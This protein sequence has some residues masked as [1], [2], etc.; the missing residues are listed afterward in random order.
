MLEQ[1][2][3]ETHQKISSRFAGRV[4]AE[5]E[6]VVPYTTAGM[7]SEAQIGH[8]GAI[9]LDCCSCRVKAYIVN[10]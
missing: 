9:L 2:T 1:Q 8:K 5:N 3:Q 7:H 4:L 6:H 10:N